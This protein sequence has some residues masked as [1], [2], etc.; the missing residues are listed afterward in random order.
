MRFLVKLFRHPKKVLL[1][2]PVVLAVNYAD[3]GVAPE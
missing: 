1:N 2:T 3:C